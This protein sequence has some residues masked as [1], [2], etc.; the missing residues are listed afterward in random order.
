M[1]TIEDL[2][3]PHFELVAMWLS[4]WQINRWLTGEW[5]GK[6]V[7]PTLIAIAVRN[8]RNR[9][10]LV[11]LDGKPCGL[12]A[13]ASI[14]MVDKV[15]MVWYLMGEEQLS[16]CGI[17]SEGVRQMVRLAFDEL[18]LKSLFTWIMEDNPASGKVL[19]KAGFREAGRIRSS[20]C[21][22]G[23]QIDRI[24]FDIVSPNSAEAIRAR[25]VG[26]R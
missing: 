9:F 13:L 14:D 16:G 2:A 5:R 18:K 22:A 23:R 8:R 25:S 12:V 24:Y 7:S 1:V 11:R 10:F 3:A 19:L 21:S 4:K 15:A 20:V 17:I 26:S 6:E